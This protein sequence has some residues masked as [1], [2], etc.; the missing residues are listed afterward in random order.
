M[1]DRCSDPA[2]CDRRHCALC[3]RGHPT[4]THPLTCPAC[5][6]RVRDQL[7]GIAELHHYARLRA[8][9]W[10]HPD[11]AIPGGAAMV[12]LGPV[13]RGIQARHL[14]Y[15]TGDYTDLEAAAKDADPPLLTLATWEDCW[16]GW[17]GQPAG[18]LASIDS[19]AAYL[20][21]NLTR[22]AQQ[23]EAKVDGDG[24]EE[25]PPDFGQFAADVQRAL[26]RLEDV[27][28]AGERDEVSKTPCLDCGTRLAR[29]YAA[30]A[31]DDRWVCPRCRRRYTEA[32][33][34]RAQHQQLAGEGADRF[35]RLGDALKAA[36]RPEY[37]VRTWVRRGL[38]S[39]YC[40]LGTRQVMVWWPDVRAL[41]RE[42][43]TR[44]LRR[45]SA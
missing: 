38:V 10:H 34:A 14:A 6:G 42:A 12:L 5:V 23:L 17:S 40:E 20:D 43:A 3:R 24:D 35:V 11:A 31:V 2:D 9:A 32:E 19:A 39:A 18:R 45:R 37:T 28:R 27:L 1:R 25:W 4:D 44:Q 21:A 13:S 8:E 41:D 29:R 33:F 22:M 15:V 7:A 16:R 26:I 36:P 30:R